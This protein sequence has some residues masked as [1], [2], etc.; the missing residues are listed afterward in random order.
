MLPLRCARR[1]PIEVREHAWQR[2]AG[3]LFGCGALPYYRRP[4]LRVVIGEVRPDKVELLREWL[5]ELN[6]PRRDEALETPADEGCRHEAAFLMEGPTGPLLAWA[7][8]AEDV[9]A[10]RLVYRNSTRVVDVEHR[11]VLREALGDPT[12]LEQ[13]LDLRP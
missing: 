5:V 11:R 10:A 9:D 6:G 1:N 8:E 4:V 13:V 2:T 7:S 12:N 3:N